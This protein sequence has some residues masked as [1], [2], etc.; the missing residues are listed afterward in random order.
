MS[1]VKRYLEREETANNL[2]E[3]LGALLE[4]EK[5]EHEASIGISKK[6]IADRSVEQL[7]TKQLAVFEHHINPLLEPDCEGHCN[8]KIDISDISNAIA[9]EFEEGGLYCQ[10]CIYDNQKMREQ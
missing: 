5:I 9:H 8:G 6:I 7:S 4:A 2:V 3:A 10:H 1:S